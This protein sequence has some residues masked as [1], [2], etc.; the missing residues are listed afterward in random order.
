MN[1]KALDHFMSFSEQK[2]KLLAR[3]QELDEGHGVYILFANRSMLFT[4]TCF[5]DG[6]MLEHF[7]FD[8]SRVCSVCLMPPFR[9][10]NFTLLGSTERLYSH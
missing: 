4:V 1:K 2:E 3:N 7:D 8:V 6:A 9:R 5:I 10:L